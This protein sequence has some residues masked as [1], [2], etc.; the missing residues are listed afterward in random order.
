[1][2][3]QTTY[4]ELQNGD[5]IWIQGYQFLASNV[6]ITSRKG[7]RTTMHGEP[8]TDDV[9]RFTGTTD[10]PAISR[11]SYNGGT[12]GGYAF[13]PITIERANGGN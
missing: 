8:N 11:T 1:M 3:R 13:A 7:E 5:H 10:N 6:R 12:Y 4:R 9:I 2:N